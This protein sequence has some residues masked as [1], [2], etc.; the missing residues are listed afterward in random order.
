[1]FRFTILLYVLIC[2]YQPANAQDKR[3]SVQIHE[4]INT[5]QQLHQT[6]LDSSITLASEALEIS[7]SLQNKYLEVTALN[8]LARFHI[9]AGNYSESLALFMRSLQLTESM[10]D[11]KSLRAAVLKGLGNIYFIQYKYDESISFYREAVSMFESVKDTQNLSS[12]YGNIAGLY[13]ETGSVDSSLYYYRK[14]LQFANTEMDK[15]SFYLN[16]GM[17]YESIDSLDEAI[18]FSEKALIIAESNNALIMMTYPLKVLSTVSRRLGDY[19]DAIEYASKSLELADQLDIIYE[20]KDAHLN[21]SASYEG[22]G[23]FEKAYHH[24]KIHKEL[25]DTLLNEDANTRLAEMR[26]KYESDKKEQEISLLT[27]RSELQQARIVSISSFLG[28]LI[29]GFGLIGFWFVSKKKKE[30]QLIEKD[31]IIAESQQQIAE[32]ELYNARL[33]EE[34]LQNELT[35]YALHIVEKNDFLEEVKSDISELRMDIKN[36]DTIRH[37]NKLGSKIYQNLTL[38]KDR[39]EFEIQIE[40]V[41]NGFFTNLEEKYP[42]LTAQEKRLAGLLRLNLSSKEIAGIMNISPKSVD[43]SRYRL[44]KK[45]NLSTEINLSTFFNQI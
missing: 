2:L 11:D 44:R 23:D 4:L 13:Y 3:D 25:N 1:M 35:N 24:Y 18:D 29:C 6:D 41:C 8:A 38:N 36:S 37:I 15:G 26:A 22:V 19:E 45:L 34:N 27:A 31:K 30:L 39:E 32:K 12:I 16:M 5:A 28:F 43:Q 7:E 9:R 17:L 42:D 10:P 14:G 21:L 33:R 40:Q 20:Q